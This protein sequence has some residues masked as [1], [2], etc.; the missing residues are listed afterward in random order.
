MLLRSFKT[1]LLNLFSDVAEKD[2]G[3]VLCSED[4]R[5]S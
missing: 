5:L 3:H 4:V 1:E 2:Y